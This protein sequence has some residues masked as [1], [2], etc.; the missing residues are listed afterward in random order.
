MKDKKLI[1][2]ALL[3]ALGVATYVFLVSFALNNASRIFGQEDNKLFAPVFFLLLFVLSALITG[4]LILAKPVML[5][6]EG[7]KKEA[8]KLLF[9][10]GA[11]LFLFLLLAG[12]IMYLLK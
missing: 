1:I 12:F 3:S 4:S 8:I 6:I 5:F 7:A 9:Y 2:R 11:G 10:T